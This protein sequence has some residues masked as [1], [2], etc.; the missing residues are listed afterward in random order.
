MQDL[1]LWEQKETVEQ[2]LRH[3]CNWAAGG[4][5]AVRAPDT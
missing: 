1:N 4:V 2:M 5:H 3:G